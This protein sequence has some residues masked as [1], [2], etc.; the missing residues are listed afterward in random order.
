MSV[1]SGPNGVENG[2]VLY[3]DAGNSKSYPGLGTNWIDMSAS[4]LNATGSAANISSTGAIAGASWTTA[5][6]SILNTDIHSIFFMIRMNSSAAWPN[7]VTGNWEKI[8]SF[9][10]WTLLL[11]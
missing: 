6:T 7:G 3:L 2:L 4:Q 1:Q 8:F 10:C 9:N 5:T 11:S